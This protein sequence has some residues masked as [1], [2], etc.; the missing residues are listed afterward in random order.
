MI[1][2]PATGNRQTSECVFRRLPF[3]I[4]KLWNVE[5]RPFGSFFF[6]LFIFNWKIIAL[7][8]RVGFC[9]WK[10]LKRKIEITRYTKNQR[11]HCWFPSSLLASVCV[12]VCVCASEHTQW[13]ALG[14]RLDWSLQAP[15]P[16]AYAIGTSV[17]SPEKWGDQSPCLGWLWRVDWAQRSPHLSKCSSQGGLSTCYSTCIWMCILM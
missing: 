16:L 8:Y 17:S 15:W 9:I 11:C 6:N 12:C 4:I 2:S 13:W 7:Q 5:H 1:I 10:F 3:L 14:P